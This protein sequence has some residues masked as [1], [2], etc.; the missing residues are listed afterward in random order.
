MAGLDFKLALSGNLQRDI[1]A[2]AAAIARGTTEG[3]RLGTDSLKNRLRTQ[4]NSAGLGQRVAKSVR[5]RVYP[6]RGASMSAA[7]VVFSQRSG[8]ILIGH[9][10]TLV[11]PG[12]GKA[13]LAIPT[14]NVPKRRRGGDF[15]G[16]GALANPFEV[17]TRFNQDLKFFRSRKGTL[18]A[19]INGLASKSKRG[20]RALPKG[21]ISRRAKIQRVIMFVMVPQVRLRKRLDF[22]TA[23][24]RE[25]DALAL[26]VAREIDR[27]LSR[28]E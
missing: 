4:I 21:K 24:A 10:G 14:E 25:A 26:T 12:N 20:W 13:Y 19:Y 22:D 5:G 7:G 8:H 6:E 11:R 1:D 23:L 9:S 15:G 17:E 2:D 3:V 16:R 18:L 27:E 28:G